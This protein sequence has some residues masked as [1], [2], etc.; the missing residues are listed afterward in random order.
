MI[1]NEWKHDAA[2]ATED[3]RLHDLFFPRQ[4]TE[5]VEE[6]RRR[7]EVA[8][9]ICAGCPV[10]IECFDYAVKYRLE[11]GVWS[12]I[13]GEILQKRR[14]RGTLRRPDPTPV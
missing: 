13:E 9:S 5:P 10:R 1:V 11:S 4:G 12:G 14:R 3:G 6:K 2:C 7:V 8:K